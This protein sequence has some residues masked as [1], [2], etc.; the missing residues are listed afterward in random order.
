MERDD[1]FLDKC[2]KG[3]TMF[4]LNQAKRVPV[5]PGR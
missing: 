5:H 2:L 4:A 3:F 1:D